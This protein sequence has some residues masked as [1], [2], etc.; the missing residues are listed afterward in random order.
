MIDGCGR[1]IDHLRLSLTDR[2]SLACTYC[3]PETRSHPSQMINFDFAMAVVS[4]LVSKHGI[5][6][7][8]LTGGEPL[9]YPRL[10]ELIEALQAL[11]ALQE[12][13][14]TTNGQALAQ[15]AHRLR[16]AGLHRINLSLDSLSPQRFATLTRGGSLDRTLDGIERA[17]A[18]GFSPVK[19]NTVVQR[20]HNDDELV[21]LTCWAI[22]RGHII[23][24]LEMMRIGPLRDR[25]DKLLVP[26]AEILQRLQVHFDLAPVGAAPG[27]PAVDY[28]AVSRD[29]KLAGKIGI[30]ASTSQPFCGRCRRIRVTADGAIMPC[31]HDPRAGSLSDGWDG[32]NLDIDAADR[33]LQQLIIGK[34]MFGPMTQALTMLSIGG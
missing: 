29:G 8:R 7:L 11:P 15:Q 10:L 18:A 1:E 14:V 31:L 3:A 32:Q 33:V 2:C 22:E 16:S 27:Q 34:S 9:L 4:W 19:I 6:H 25:A 21:N 20:G 30:I 26:A 28:Q 24:F 17:A 23:R 5:R 13:A 12:I